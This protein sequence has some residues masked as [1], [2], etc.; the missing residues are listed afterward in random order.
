MGTT[1]KAPAPKQNERH[2][3]SV[4]EQVKRF[5]AEHPELAAFI[6]RHRG[7]VAVAND[8]T[9]YYRNS[10]AKVSAKVLAEQ[11]RAHFPDAF[12]AVATGAV[13]AAPAKPSNPPATPGS[14]SPTAMGNTFWF[15]P[16]SAEARRNA[17]AT[18]PPKPNVEP[19]DK[20]AVKVTG[21]SA[22]LEK[23]A[24]SV[25]FTTSNAAN[26][27]GSAASKPTPT[28]KSKTAAELCE[29]CGYVAAYAFAQ[30]LGWNYSSFNAFAN[31]PNFPRPAVT[32]PDGTRLYK[33][34][35]ADAFCK[36]MGK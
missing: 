9:L 2:G 10:N 31:N 36:R 3:L 5:K 21:M 19:A 32:M 28:E 23:F 12:N 24:A 35:D 20:L 1:S 29:V 13:P 27:S 6:A 26:L 30:R 15:E 17:A 25:K 11:F 8:L 33:Q 34:A 4:A 22:G 18:A 16:K 7:N 14:T